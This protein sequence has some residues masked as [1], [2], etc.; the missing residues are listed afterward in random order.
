MYCCQDSASGRSVCGDTLPA[1]C[2]GRAY[3]VLDRAGNLVRE[4]AA[5]LTPE[6]KAAA[7][8]AA[9]E[10]KRIED[11]QREQ[12]RKDQALLTTYPTLADID[13]LQKKAEGEA[14]RALQ[15][16]R[17]EMVELQHKQRKLANEAEFYKRR[18]MPVDLA[19]QLRAN[20]HEIQLQQE[21]IA[22]R[23]KELVATSNKY[24]ADR[25][26]YL[27]LTGGRPTGTR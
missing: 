22:L 21:L 19:N 9:A 26:R 1:Q 7:A 17:D 3:R 8:A 15:E 20:G 11:A 12:W 23:N 10:Q 24:E 13:Y 18:S 16:A 2:R 5:P 6:Q 14:R 25:K 27:E 4:V